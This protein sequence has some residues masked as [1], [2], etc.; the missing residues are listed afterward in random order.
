MADFHKLEA[1]HGQQPRHSAGDA[2]VDNN[3]TRVSFIADGVRHGSQEQV[4]NA[5]TLQL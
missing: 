2:A 4:Y 3:T 5:T 1:T